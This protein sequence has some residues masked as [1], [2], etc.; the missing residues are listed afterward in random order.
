MKWLWLGEGTYKLRDSDDSDPEGQC[1]NVGSAIQS[2]PGIDIILIV[3]HRDPSI[4]RSLGRRFLIDEIRKGWDELRPEEIGKDE[5]QVETD[6]TCGRV[7]GPLYMKLSILCQLS[8]VVGERCSLVLRFEWAQ[9][10]DRVNRPYT[11]A[12]NTFSAFARVAQ[13]SLGFKAPRWFYQGLEC[14]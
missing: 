13:T 1:W 11:R 7:Y 14:E 8:M 6:R 12:C 2:P 5:M 10:R 4:W 3:D 9:N